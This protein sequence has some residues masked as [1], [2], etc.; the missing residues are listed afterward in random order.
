MQ[1]EIKTKHHVSNCVWNDLEMQLHNNNTTQ[2]TSHAMPIL[3][4]FFDMSPWRICIRRHNIRMYP[5][6]WALHYFKSLLSPTFTT[7]Q[8]IACII[9]NLHRF[10]I[11]F[12]ITTLY[13]KDNNSSFDCKTYFKFARGRLHD[14]AIFFLQH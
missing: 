14:E 8:K 13:S 3:I 2:T 11:K 7:Q 4:I 1:R 5:A 12:I 6:Q 9:F 10:Y